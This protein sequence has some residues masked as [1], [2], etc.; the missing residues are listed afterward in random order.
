MNV[1]YCDICGHPIKGETFLLSM[2]SLTRL[3]ELRQELASQPT[4]YFEGEHPKAKTID[5][6]RKEMCS[7]CKEIV[8]LIFKG[9]R[10]KALKILASLKADL[11]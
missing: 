10:K 1:S 2:V 8:D 3:N 7:S 6:E 9:R 5:I 11:K 4:F